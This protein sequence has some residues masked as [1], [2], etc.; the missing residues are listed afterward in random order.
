MFLG[1][2]NSHDG[3]A[4]RDDDV[5]K[6]SPLD[7]DSAPEGGMPLLL[8]SG[9]LVRRVVPLL[10]LLRLADGFNNDDSDALGRSRAD[11]RPNELDGRRCCIA[12]GVSRLL[13]D[14]LLRNR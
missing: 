11:S 14:M 9:V 5:D 12:T 3:S 7:M 6:E 4:R 10:L 1:G 2:S 8:R 13:G